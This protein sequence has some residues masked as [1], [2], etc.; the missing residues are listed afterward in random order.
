VIKLHGIGIGT[1]KLIKVDQVPE[2]NTHTPM[3][4]LFLAKLFNGGK[5]A[6]STNHVGLSV[7]M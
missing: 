4:T 5:K 7:C 1:D 3:G 2:I 6:Y